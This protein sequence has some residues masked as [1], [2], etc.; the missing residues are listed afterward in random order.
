MIKFKSTLASLAILIL[1]ACQ[2]TPQAATST[3]VPSLAPSAIPALSPETSPETAVPP[4]AQITTPPNPTTDLSESLS[5]DWN[6]PEI[7]RSGLIP[8]AR[9][10]ADLLATAPVYSMTVNIDPAAGLVTGFQLIRYT[11]NENVTLDEIFLH[12]FPNLLGGSSEISNLQVDGHEV[13]WLYENSHASVMRVP[14]ATPLQPGAAALLTMDFVTAVPQD[15]GRNYGVFAQVDNVMALAH[16]YPLVAVYDDS[17][18]HIDPP[19]EFGDPTF[20]DAGF[21]LVNV[22]APDDQVVVGSG[23]VV[24]EADNGRF[25]TQTLA[26]GPARDFYL[27][28]SPDFAVATVT[29]DETT[30]HSYAPAAFAEGAKQ[31]AEVAANALRVFNPR[32]GTYPYTELDIVATPTLA[33]GIEYPGVIAIT[34]REYDPETP[35]YEGMPNSVFLETTVAHEMGHQ[36]FYNIVGNDQLLEPWL[37]EAMAQ[38]V[39]GLYY[40]DLYGTSA[41]ESYR[42]SWDD[43]WSHVNYADT[44]IGLPVGVYDGAAYSAIIYGRGPLFIEALAAEMGQDTLTT[45]LQAYTNQNKW[46]IATTE[47]FKTLAEATCQCRLTELFDAWV[48]DK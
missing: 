11:N 24:D 35:I 12:L 7:Y 37:D 31:A 47:S 17:G 29:V 46:D 38:Y 18:W 27:V 28:L 23:V 39:T 40:E 45:F 22:S 19:V 26:A 30:I 43:R 21:Y 41:A 4:V 5:F 36:W 10:S 42:Q 16:F 14:L 25:H 33:L 6:D 1:V 8:S 3:A 13:E 15:V 9:D 32:L 20:T 48:Y 34:Q 2:H 44:P